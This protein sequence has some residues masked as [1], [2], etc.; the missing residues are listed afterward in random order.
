MIYLL[1]VP[2]HRI[3]LQ[4]GSQVLNGKIKESA[5]ELIIDNVDTRIFKMLLQVNI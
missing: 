4:T 5:K 1:Q 2:V 3:F